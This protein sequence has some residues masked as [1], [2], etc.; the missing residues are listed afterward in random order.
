MTMEGN[1]VV[2]EVQVNEHGVTL[3]VILDHSLNLKRSPHVVA[4][5]LHAPPA[6]RFC[7][8]CSAR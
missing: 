4:A 1:P 6:T 5:D 7:V 3:K 2:A 8:D